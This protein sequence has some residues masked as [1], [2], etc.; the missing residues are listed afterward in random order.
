MAQGKP[1]GDGGAAATAADGFGTVMAVATKSD[2]N[3]CHERCQRSIRRRVCH[4]EDIRVVTLPRHFVHFR[5]CEPEKTV[6]LS[7]KSLI[8]NVIND[9]SG[10]AAVSE[11][12]KQPSERCK[13]S[14]D[15]ALKAPNKL[16]AMRWRSP[17]GSGRSDACFL[18]AKYSDAGNRLLLSFLRVGRYETGRYTVS[19]ESQNA[20]FATVSQN[21]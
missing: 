20:S 5:A 13:M 14:Q 3:G 11:T 18:L 17:R 4:T 19:P 21:R 8:S 10:Q 2:E 1:E 9:I 7:P 15:G 6:N 12:R 16:A